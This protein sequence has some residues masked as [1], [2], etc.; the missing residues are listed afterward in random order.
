[1]ASECACALSLACTHKRSENEVAARASNTMAFARKSVATAEPRCS[2][3]RIMG[4]A[5]RTSFGGDQAAFKK[6]I[7]KFA[8]SISGALDLA[9]MRSR[10]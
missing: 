2:V 5:V 4:R 10:L 6:L 1:M 3:N 7:A 8:E 9:R